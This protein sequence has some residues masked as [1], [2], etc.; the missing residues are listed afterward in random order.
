M[1]F[2]KFLRQRS[3]QPALFPWIKGTAMLVIGRGSEQRRMRLPLSVADRMLVAFERAL[4]ADVAGDHDA[5]LVNAIWFTR[6]EVEDAI[7]ALVAETVRGPGAVQVC[8]A[9]ALAGS[10]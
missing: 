2:E 8:A 4:R 5:I 7:A 9:H 6:E 10:V 3:I 1:K